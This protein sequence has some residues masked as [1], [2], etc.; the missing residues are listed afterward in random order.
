MSAV[1]SSHTHR[2]R[3]ARLLTYGRVMGFF[4]WATTQRFSAS[5]VVA[6]MICA[7]HVSFMSLLDEHCY[8]Y[9]FFPNAFIPVIL[10]MLIE[11]YLWNLELRVLLLQVYISLLLLKA[12]Y[13]GYDC[14][15]E[16]TLREFCLTLCYD[17]ML[18]V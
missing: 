2:A 17:V 1:L 14:M 8:L 9:R 13:L 15:H 12:I 10:D 18:C 5:A 4:P 6:A 7:L 16:V 11:A 3:K